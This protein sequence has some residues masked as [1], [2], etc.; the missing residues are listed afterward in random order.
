MVLLDREP[1]A[2][3]C[4]LLNAA[5]NGLPPVVAAAATAADAPS[6]SRSSG[7]GSG[8]GGV[9]VPSLESLLP[10]LAAEDVERLQQHQAR[11]AQQQQRRQQ[12]PAAGTAEGAAAAA[13]APAAAAAGLGAVRAE[14]FDWSQPVTLAP[15]DVCLVCDCLYEAFSVQVRW[16]TLVC[17]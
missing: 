11:L 16:R 3:Q 2:L 9:Q 8:G 10:F 14:L 5:I 13:A 6:S 15:H 17:V 4:A 12:A 1:L 7:G